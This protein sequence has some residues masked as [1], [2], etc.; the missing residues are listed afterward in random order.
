[1]D[2]NLL[3]EFAGTK[4]NSLSLFAAQDFFKNVKGRLRDQLKRLAVSAAKRSAALR[5]QFKNEINMQKAYG[6][7]ISHVPGQR[8]TRTLQREIITGLLK[9][10]TSRFSENDGIDLLHTIVP[11]NTADW[12]EG[13]FFREIFGRRPTPQPSASP[14]PTLSPQSRKTD[15]A[16][17]ISS[18]ATAS[19]SPRQKESGSARLRRARRLR[20]RLMRQDSLLLRGASSGP[21][22]D[23]LR[24]LR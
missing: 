7:P 2:M 20:R 22:A 17:L 21:F 5:D 23:C 10:G 8:A 24:R 12:R 16:P 4:T 1:M 6:R 13:R 14:T 11:E 3:A 9:N 19:L 18:T 15:S